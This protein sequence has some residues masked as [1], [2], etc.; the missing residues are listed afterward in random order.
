MSEDKIASKVPSEFDLSRYERISFGNFDKE[1]NNLIIGN[2][3]IY[4]TGVANDEP[5][6]M[7]ELKSIGNPDGGSVHRDPSIPLTFERRKDEHVESESFNYFDRNKPLFIEIND[8]DEK[9]LL[10]ELQEKEE[11]MKNGVQTNK[12]G[13]PIHVERMVSND[14]TEENNFKPDVDY[15]KKNTITRI[16]FCKNLNKNS[17]TQNDTLNDSKTFV[18]FKISDSQNIIPKI[19]TNFKSNKEKKIIFHVF[20]KSGKN[21]YSGENQV[22]NLHKIFN[23]YDSDC[24]VIII[25]HDELIQDTSENDD[26]D[27]GTG[28]E[29]N[30]YHGGKRKSRKSRK[31]KKARK[32]RKSKKSRK[33]KTRKRNRKTRRH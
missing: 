2:K 25:N 18:N 12:D 9:K 19:V 33:K 26:T 31:S 11:N 3:Y 13:N 29:G 27:T 6:Y 30:P 17:Y 8:D 10:R 7:G 1:K 22:S 21:I 24:I 32:A 23:T 28:M 5:R 15:F 4:F 16:I 20:N 14:K